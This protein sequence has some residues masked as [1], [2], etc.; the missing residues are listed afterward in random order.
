MSETENII[1][2]VSKAEFEKT[3]AEWG[4]DTFNLDAAAWAKVVDELKGR[5]ENFLD[6]LW[7]NVAQDYLEGLDEDESP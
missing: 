3:L 4:D 7:E 5:I 1:L 6:E 2:P